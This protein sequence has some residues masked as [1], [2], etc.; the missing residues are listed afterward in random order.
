MPTSRRRSRVFLKKNKKKSLVTQEDLNSRLVSANQTLM[1]QMEE[2][3]QRDMETTLERQKKQGK[4]LRDL[5][6]D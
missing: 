5:M 3:Q 2:Q 4:I 1:Q 6:G